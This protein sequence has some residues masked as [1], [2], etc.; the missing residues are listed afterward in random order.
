M[1]ELRST[2][3]YS[4][5]GAAA[6]VKCLANV[7]NAR[8]IAARGAITL[9]NTLGSSDSALGRTASAALNLFS[10]LQPDHGIDFMAT[11]ILKN[12]NTPVMSA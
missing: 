10:L 6:A 4:G 12:A 3:E 2:R 8:G 11:A 5:A 7:K 9:A 1:S